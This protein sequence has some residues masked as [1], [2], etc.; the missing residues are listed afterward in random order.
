MELLRNA[1]LAPL[2]TFGVPARAEVL[3]RF[4]DA[5]QLRSLLAA[6]ELAGMPRMVLGGGS[7]VLFTRDFPGAV[8]V[9]EVPGIRV[10]REDDHHVWLQAGAGEVW[11]TLV[12]HA[13]D[14]GWGGLENLSLIPGKVGAAPMQNI[15]AYGVELKDTFVE[16]EALR[17]SDGEVVTFDRDAC[18]FGYRES[19][20]KREGK[21]RFI[22]LNV[23]FRLAKDPE[24]NTSYGAIREVLFE[25][26]ITDPG[27][28]EVSD[29]VIA[30][31]RSK[32]PDPKELG[33]AGSFFK[34]PVVPE[35]DYERIR[36]AHPDV[37]AYPAGDGLR[38]LAAGWLIERAGWK[39]H[40]ANGHGVHAAQ[41]LV[42]VNHGGARGADIEALSRR[43]MDDIRA[44]FGV[45]LEREVNII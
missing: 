20:F 14:Q 40:R 28:K 35:A 8:L 3:A 2:T 5:D 38:K 22:I 23:T 26:G 15:G 30:I 24:L 10:V 41:A 12:L 39:G 9:N 4:R 27:V 42:L 6:P 37:V 34:N 16:L 11:H 1:D 7:N 36:R 19:F 21:D 17:I 29:A 44:R 32:L 33:N 13:V 43:I 18:T 25:R 31:R 45:E